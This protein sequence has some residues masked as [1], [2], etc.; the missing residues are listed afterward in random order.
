MEANNNNTDSKESLV[1]RFTKQFES[2]ISKGN[3]PSVVRTGVTSTGARAFTTSQQKVSVYSCNVD[4]F[5]TVFFP[6]YNVT[7]NSLAYRL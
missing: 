5:W 6:I 4:V 1:A 3:N 7:Q 2:G